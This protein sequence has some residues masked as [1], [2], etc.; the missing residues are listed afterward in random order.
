MGAAYASIP[1]RVALTGVSGFIGSCLARHLSAA[2]HGVVGLVRP[3][4]RRDRAAPF[5]ERFVTGD[6]AD[7]SCWPALLKGAECVIHNSV[8]WAPLGSFD[9]GAPPQDL[10]EHLRANLC[11]SIE[12]LR[13]S[14]PRQFIFVSSIAVHHDMRTRWGGVID[15]DHPLRPNTLYGAY[16]AAVEAHLW[17]AHFGQGRNA[18]AF[19]PC[20]VYGIDP[21]LARSHGYD[22]V[23]HLRE[24]RPYKEPGGG[25]YVHVDDTAAAITAAVGNPAVAG[26][27]FNLVDCYARWADMAAM[28]AELLG[29][30]AEIDFS[31]PARPKN[32]FTKDAAR[33][34]GVSLDRGHAGLRNHFAELIR[35]MD[36][37]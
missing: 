20:G 26:R 8:D 21:E 25:K 5:V 4:S 9:A 30:R 28:I 11:A 16:K 15:E 23:Q 22:I 12:L 31:S 3:S 1:M 37:R 34:L 32:T 19:R 2:G 29:V 35:A 7:Q 18:S 33:S 6:Q 24:G 14:A 10:R 36:S 17:A 27:A 13:A